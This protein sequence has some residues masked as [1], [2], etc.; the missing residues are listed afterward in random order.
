M[1]FSEDICTRTV[2]STK[3]K[4]NHL[5]FRFQMR[6]LNKYNTAGAHPLFNLINSFAIIHDI[7]SYFGWQR[8]YIQ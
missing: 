8:R 7:H 6:D 2:I 4:R 5:L 1:Y 3:D